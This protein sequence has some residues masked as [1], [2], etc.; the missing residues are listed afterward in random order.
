M[1]IISFKYNTESGDYEQSIDREENPEEKATDIV[2]SA[3][4][5]LVKI[6]KEYKEE[7]D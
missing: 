7:G 5:V 2:I 1:A 6:Y 3:I 4:Q